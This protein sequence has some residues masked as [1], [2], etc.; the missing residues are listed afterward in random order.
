MRHGPA[1]E[2]TSTE[3]RIVAKPGDPGLI[4]FPKNA[5]QP[6]VLFGRTLCAG[7]L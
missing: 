5:R 2:G 4:V 7:F 3:R 1:L 6:Q